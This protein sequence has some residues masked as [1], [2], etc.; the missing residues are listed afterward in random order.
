MCDD[1]R[2][3]SPTCSCGRQS[4]STPT[5]AD[6][7][8][9]FQASAKTEESFASLTLNDVEQQELYEAAKVIQ[10]AYRTYRGRKR[11]ASELLISAPSSSNHFSAKQPTEESVDAN[12]MMCI[13]SDFEMGECSQYLRVGSG[14]ADQS[15]RQQ[16][17]QASARLLHH[18]HREQ[19][20]LQSAPT[21]VKCYHDREM[22]AAT[23]IQACYRRY[24]QYVNFKRQQ[25]SCGASD[26]RRH[27]SSNQRPAS[28]EQQF[29]S[30]TSGTNNKYWPQSAQFVIETLPIVIDKATSSHVDRKRFK[31]ASL[32]NETGTNLAGKCPLTSRTRPS[33]TAITDQ[34]STESNSTNASNTTA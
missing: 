29:S 30:S 1:G 10:K 16:P 25:G 26:Q 15:A 7:C 14:G 27:Y 20:G 9:Y 23:I 3:L 17:Q 2:E 21:L 12:E 28:S 11:Q 31:T 24:R 22:Q 4:S 5:S 13:D 33:T 19:I 34:S 32:K 18:Q 6:F 8:E